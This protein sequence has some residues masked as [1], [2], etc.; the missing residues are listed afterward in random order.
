MS[1]AVLRSRFSGIAYLSFLEIR[2]IVITVVGKTYNCFAE[3]ALL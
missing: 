3:D 1:L 2:P